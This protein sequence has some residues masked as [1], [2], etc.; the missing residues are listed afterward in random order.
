[1]VMSSKGVNLL[2]LLQ[3]ER[4]Y[5]VPMVFEVRHYPLRAILTSVP[6]HLVSLGHQ[7]LLIGV[8]L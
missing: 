2:L 5:L 7:P 1:M 6:R 4:I 3:D 8:S